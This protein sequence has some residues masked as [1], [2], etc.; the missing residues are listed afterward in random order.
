MV[1]L[2][3][4]KLT[5]D[6]LPSPSEPNL[7]SPPK[8][9]LS[10]LPHPT[11]KVPT[12]HAKEAEG[13]PLINS[14]D[15]TSVMKRAEQGCLERGSPNQSMN[16]KPNAAD[17]KKG[18]RP[19][20]S[21]MARRGSHATATHGLKLGR[22][23]SRQTNG[24]ES[25]P[26][27]QRPSSTN[28]FHRPRTHEV[29]STQTCTYK[30]RQKTGRHDGNP[31]LFHT[32]QGGGFVQGSS[33]KAQE[34]L[35]NPILQENTPDIEQT[36][37][38]LDSPMDLDELPRIQTPLTGMNQEPC[39][40]ENDSST[41]CPSDERLAWVSDGRLA[42]VSESAE[43]A[44]NTPNDEERLEQMS[45]PKKQGDGTDDAPRK[46]EWTCLGLHER[47]WKGLACCRGGV[48]KY[49]S[50]PP[51]TTRS[52][53]QAFSVWV[54]EVTRHF[55]FFPRQTKGKPW[56]HRLR[57][58]TNSPLRRQPSN[59][60]PKPMFRA[61][62]EFVTCSR[63]HQGWIQTAMRTGLHQINSPKKPIN[64]VCPCEESTDEPTQVET[65]TT[66]QG[67][68]RWDC[69]RHPRQDG[70]VKSTWPGCEVKPVGD[71]SLLQ[72]HSHNSHTHPRQ[73]VV[74]ADDRWFLCGGDPPRGLS[75]ETTSLGQWVQ[76]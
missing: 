68:L 33:C 42:W 74:I 14:T 17:D 66:E 50:V 2:Q 27:Q 56:K 55:H 54:A 39:D 53:R 36:N 19:S 26:T 21:L 4:L 40:S 64:R 1:A 5:R 52:T 48:S 51:N 8:S 67:T 9:G 12:Y 7:I 59:K 25:D 3:P 75:D 71:L 22:S 76:R 38:A 15:E 69:T 45:H 30:S 65:S 24:E 16:S 43:Q 37:G 44:V 6:R 29:E 60:H 49:H 32:T 11:E 35:P 46:V 28:S 57:E 61:R 20:Q 18:D 23:W 41:P 58:R 13:S 47:L 34:N 73:D 31:M 70:N 62:H 72:Y 10:R 63:T